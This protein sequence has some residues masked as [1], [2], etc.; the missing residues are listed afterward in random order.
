MEV[1]KL[2]DITGIENKQPKL[3]NFGLDLLPDV[4]G[5]S[6]L[7]MLS[8]GLVHCNVVGCLDTAVFKWRFKNEQEDR[9]QVLAEEG[10]IIQFVGNGTYY[11]EV[12]CGISTGSNQVAQ[13]G[14]F[15]N[16]FSDTIIERQTAPAT[17]TRS[18]PVIF[19]W[20]F[21]KIPKK[22]KS[23][24]RKLFKAEKWKD[25]ALLHNKWRLSQNGYCCDMSGVKANFGKYLGYE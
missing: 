6:G 13:R 19:E 5:F 1:E 3:G 20:D 16:T 14:I 12:S 9:V 21:E 15:T 25:L 8:G 2:P 17:V 18:E 7:V 22:E 10:N 24:I 23:K 11:A 4:A